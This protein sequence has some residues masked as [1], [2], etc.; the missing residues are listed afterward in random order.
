M[1]RDLAEHSG[2][3]KRAACDVLIV[4]AGIAGLLMATRLRRAGLKVVVV[5]SGGWTQ[6][7]DT[8]PLNEVVQ[9][10]Q[11]YSGADH[12]RFRCLGGT[13]TRWGGAMIPFSPEDMG[14]HTSGWDITWGMSYDDV[15]HYLPE[16]EQL[17]RLPA[18]D[19]NA[20]E[21]H[22]MNNG[23]APE[24][25]PRLA[26]WP[27]F[28]RRNVAT[29]LNAEL[30]NDGGLEIWLNATVT[31][32]TFDA[33]GLMTGVKARS[34]TGGTLSVAAKTT[35]IAAGAIE[36]TRLLLIADADHDNR[37]FMPDDVL[38]KHFYD[39][40]S[41]PVANVIPADRSTLNKLTG[42][43]FEHGGMRNLRFELTGAARRR[44]KLPAA[45]THIS[46]STEASGGFDALRNVL[47]AIQRRSMPNSDDMISLFRG[48]KWL[49]RAL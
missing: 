26:K 25:S 2:N 35:V 42:F 16:I 28:R 29:L 18:G 45:F 41:A 21:L 34:L 11:P 33:G 37:I 27:A 40:L 22:D 24:F 4:G 30:R 32:L 23:S 8:H 20:P 49:A 44:H 5:E 43:R 14:P 15:V 31:E 6:L 39:H 9:V 48:S 1:I 7:E 12:G 13:S 38:G 10:G 17:F 46:F 3:A 47:R 36:S 19:Y